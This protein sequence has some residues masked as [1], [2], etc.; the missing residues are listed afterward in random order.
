MANISQ[1]LFPSLAKTSW[2]GYFFGDISHKPDNR[3][4]SFHNP[5]IREILLHENREILFHDNIEILFH[6]SQITEK[7]NTAELDFTQ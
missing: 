6:T 2:L 7:Y 1:S 4:I 3:E 5:D